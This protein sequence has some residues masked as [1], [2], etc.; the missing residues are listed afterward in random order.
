MNL[1]GKHYKINLKENK[2]KRLCKGITSVEAN[3]IS[4]RVKESCYGAYHCIFLD[5]VLDEVHIEV[6]PRKS[7]FSVTDANS[8]KMYYSA[9][10][11]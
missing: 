7:V 2:L 1:N 3:I 11:R 9:N 4:E 10:Q 5:S 6:G 8:L